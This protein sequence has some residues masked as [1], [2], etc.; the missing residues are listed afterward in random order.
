[1]DAPKLGALAFVDQLAKN[2]G[3][4]AQQIK[5]IEGKHSRSR[6]YSQLYSEGSCEWES[7]A[8]EANVTTGC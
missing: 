7:A 2:V 1:M 8:R 6:C 5:L 3:R 4:L